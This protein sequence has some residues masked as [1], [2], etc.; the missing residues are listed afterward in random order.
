MKRAE[1]TAEVFMTALESL[2]RSDR[3]MI[4]QRLFVDPALKEDFI[5]VAAWYERRTKR[6]VPLSASESSPEKGRSPVNYCLAI[7]PSAS[8]AGAVG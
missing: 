4:L 5:D 8:R 7:K 3:G 2:P 6:V 1:A